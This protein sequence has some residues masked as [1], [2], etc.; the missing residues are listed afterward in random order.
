MQSYGI[1]PWGDVSRAYATAGY[2]WPPLKKPRYALVELVDQIIRAYWLPRFREDE[3]GETYVRPEVPSGYADFYENVF[4]QREQ[5]NIEALR[6]VTKDAVYR[7][8]PILIG[9]SPT[10]NGNTLMPATTITREVIVALDSS[11]AHIVDLNALLSSEP[12][13][14]DIY[15]DNVHFNA[16]GHAIIGKKLGSTLQEHISDI[17][18]RSNR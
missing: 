4:A 1:F 13:I 3:E 8:T 16:R 10:R 2:L 12:N 6:V 5:K 9:V 17:P 15:I 11:G 7:E 14:S 18:K